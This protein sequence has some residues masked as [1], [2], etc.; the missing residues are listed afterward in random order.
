MRSLQ[1]NQKIARRN[2]KQP[3]TLLRAGI[4]KCG[5]CGRSLAVHRRSRFYN[6]PEEHLRHLAYRCSTV[7]SSL[8]PCVGCSI[9]VPFLDNAVWEKALEII[10]DP[11]IIDE[12]IARR[13][14]D[15]PTASRRKQINKLLA[16]IRNEQNDL[17]TTLLRMIKERKLDRKTENL[18][19]SRLKE[20]E[21]LEH[22]YNSELLDDNKIHQ[23][24]AEA[25]KELEKLHK[26]CAV[27]RE[28][29]GDPAYVPSYETKRELIEF[30]G[31]TVRLWNA[32]HKPRFEI[33]V[34]PLNI[35]VQLS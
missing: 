15:D 14:S 12:E 25:Q 13:R 35:V 21:K 33:Q 6:E 20:L 27:M 31:M 29:L 22:E 28:K 34:N 19:A 3:L 10:R 1:H 32:E 2:N 11:S 26:K 24:W 16:E 18:L 23:Q 9:I 30:F 7:S 17:Q 8:H 4:A 5:H